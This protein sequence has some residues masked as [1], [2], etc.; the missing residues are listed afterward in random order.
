MYAETR[1]IIG[2]VKGEIGPHH[3]DK[4]GVTIVGWDVHVS[5]DFKRTWNNWECAHYWLVNV[6]LGTLTPEEGEL[7]IRGDGR[8]PPGSVGI[9]PRTSGPAGAARSKTG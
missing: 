2:N 5:R 3:T 7:L 6:M 4:A 8:Y 1:I 9:T